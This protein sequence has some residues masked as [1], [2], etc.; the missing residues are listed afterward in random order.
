MSTL[1]SIRLSA[2]TVAVLIITGISLLLLIGKRL[3]LP[4][5]GGEGAGPQHDAQLLTQYTGENSFPHARL[6]PA[7]LSRG[8]TLTTNAYTF[9]TYT[10]NDCRVS[11][12]ENTGI[13]LQDGREHYNEFTLL[14]GRIVASGSCVF[15]T[16]ETKVSIEGATTLVHFSW[17]D[18][19]VIKVFRG[20]ATVSQ[21]GTITTLTPESSATQFSTLPSNISQTSVEFSTGF[22][23]IIADFY[24]WGIT[25]QTLDEAGE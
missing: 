17:L 12:A 7:T 1:P 24:A 19:I 15:L 3:D 21:S 13:T 22:N 14:T 20:E 25:P 6:L 18:Q 10:M 2:P 5:A 23:D 4:F 9:A 11:L 16:R 8:E